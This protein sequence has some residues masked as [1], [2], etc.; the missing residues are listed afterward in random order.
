MNT[1]YRLTPEET[2]AYD[3]LKAA[4]KNMTSYMKFGISHYLKGDKKRFRYGLEQLYSMGV[5]DGREIEMERLLGNDTWAK[6]KAAVECECEG[7]GYCFHKT[8]T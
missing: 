8:T 1:L 2:A 6:V 7:K 3:A 5:Y 4:A